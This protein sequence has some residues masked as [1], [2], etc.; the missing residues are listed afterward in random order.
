MNNN[1]CIKKPALRRVYLWVLFY[2]R[3]KRLN[4]NVGLVVTLFGEFYQ[5]VNF[6]VKGVVF[7]KVNVFSRIV[8]CST[9]TN[10]N[11]SSSGGLASKNLDTQAFG[12]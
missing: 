3:V 7:T 4:R 10:D 12:F 8:G 11:V 5:S 1:Y 6:S 9:L 2:L